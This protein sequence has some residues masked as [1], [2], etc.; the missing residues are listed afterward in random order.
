[1]GKKIYVNIAHLCKKQGISYLTYTLTIYIYSPTPKKKKKTLLLN[2]TKQV[3]IG[4]LTLLTV[5]C[6]RI[7]GHI[8][9]KGLSSN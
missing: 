9:I 4:I 8:M 1:M 2:G 6:K 3:F 7:W 5:C